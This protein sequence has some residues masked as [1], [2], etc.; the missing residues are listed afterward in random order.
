MRRPGKQSFSLFPLPLRYFSRSTLF[1]WLFGSVP[2]A[3]NAKPWTERWMAVKGP[4]PRGTREGL[5]GTLLFPSSAF[6]PARVKGWFFALAHRGLLTLKGLHSFSALCYFRLWV[7][8]LL[9]RGD[10]SIGSLQQWSQGRERHHC[11]VRLPLQVS[12]NCV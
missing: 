2:C 11:F 7:L 5:K 12:R 3:V 8:R 6:A 10:R 9:Q 4:F 1:I